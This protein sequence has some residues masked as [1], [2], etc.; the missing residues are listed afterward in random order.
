[1]NINIQDLK[2]K[3]IY[4]SAY[5]GTKEMD[6]LLGSFSK[7]YVNILNE[8]DLVCLSKL[9]D[10][11]DENLYKY[12]QGLK[13]TVKINENKVTKLFRDFVYKKI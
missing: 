1:M 2:K 10:I 11:D 3:I 9:M 6:L 13:T 4:R 7:K 5:R 12:N 8:E